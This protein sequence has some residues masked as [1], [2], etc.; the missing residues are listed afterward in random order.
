MWQSQVF[1]TKIGS[2][3]VFSM[4]MG[5]MKIGSMKIGSMKMWQHEDVAVT[6]NQHEDRHEKEEA[7]KNRACMEHIH[8]PMV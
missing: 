7:A 2:M 3:K 5:S 8:S 6:G 4:K 1:S